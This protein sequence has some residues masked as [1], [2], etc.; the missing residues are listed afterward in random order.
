MRT[1]G[2]AAAAFLRNDRGVGLATAGVRKSR[3]SPV[4]EPYIAPKR[5][6]LTAVAG[7][8]RGQACQRTFDEHS[9]PDRP[10]HTGAIA[11]TGYTGAGMHKTKH[12]HIAPVYHLARPRRA[13]CAWQL[14]THLR[15]VARKSAGLKWATPTRRKAFPTART[16]APLRRLAARNVLIFALQ[17][18][19]CG[20]SCMTRVPPSGT[21]RRSAWDAG[22]TRAWLHA[23]RARLRCRRAAIW[24]VLSR[25]LASWPGAHT[26]KQNATEAGRVRRERAPE[27]AR[28]QRARDR[29]AA[30]ITFLR[31]RRRVARVG[32][33]LPQAHGLSAKTSI[34]ATRTRR[35]FF[36]REELDSD[37]L[38]SCNGDRT[39]GARKHSAG[40][41]SDQKCCG[42]LRP[43]ASCPPV[44]VPVGPERLVVR[45]DD[46][47]RCDLP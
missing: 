10:L 43:C 28:V 46:S 36:S 39:G 31:T 4:N 9:C 30:G 15:E 22:S 7:C 11:G 41:W 21:P 33:P 29:F 20:G 45:R 34:D 17:C 26:S 13:H 1:S 24:A 35:F 27:A 23:L 12:V 32:S 40:G 37:N 3:R 18:H 2:A 47:M 19:W 6:L 44:A 25:F 14:R 8:M 42:A 16:H 5:D 38:E